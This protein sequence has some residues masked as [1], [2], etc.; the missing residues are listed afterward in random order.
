MRVH[1]KRKGGRGVDNFQMEG[2]PKEFGG[3]TEE[4][5][6]V[7]SPELVMIPTE[8]KQT[9]MTKNQCPQHD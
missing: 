5:R 1:S 2:G 3:S 9:T 4:S 6:E 8:E 7:M